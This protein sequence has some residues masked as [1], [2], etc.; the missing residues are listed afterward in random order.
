MRDTLT[1]YL[2]LMRLHKP[3]GIFL[4]LWPTLW[5]VM[6]ASHGSPSLSIITVF[7]LGTVLMRSAGCVINDYADKDFDGHVMR[8]RERPLVTKRVTT[9]QALII[10]SIL[11]LLSLALVLTLN[12]LTLLLAIPALLLAISYP[13]MKR[14]TNMPQLI[15][16]IAFSWGIP[17]AFAAI[18]N[19]VPSIAW[20]MML[21]NIFWVIAY[22][23]QYAMI[24]REDDLKIGVKSSAILFGRYDRLII[25]LL[26]ISALIVLI[27]IGAL[28][29]M[30]KWYYASLIITALLCS[31]QGYLIHDRDRNNC[32]RAF[33]N[34][35]W[36]GMVIA[37]GVFVSYHT[38]C[39]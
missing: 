3:I 37:I 34:N 21:A 36:V 13:F 25:A 28:Q 16:G 12:R 23:S 26:Q 20:L 17:M 29:A 7:V 33:K 19:S 5:A 38:P 30:N 9:K 2:I 31:Y 15:L 32:L 10:F 14:F 8:T 11:S 24:D 22:D 39:G 4:L 6:I 27:L 18:N 35:H 1:Q